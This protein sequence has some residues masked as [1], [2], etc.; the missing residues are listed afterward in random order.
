M[1]KQFRS[2]IESLI[3]NSEKNTNVFILIID[4]KNI[5]NIEKDLELFI[6]QNKNIVFKNINDIGATFENTLIEFLERIIAA[7]TNKDSILFPNEKAQKII[8][9]LYGK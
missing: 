6:I 5:L 9:D 1:I 8:T 2:D 3:K 7:R 4:N